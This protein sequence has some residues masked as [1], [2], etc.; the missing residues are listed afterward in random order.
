M[1]DVDR[2]A[3]TARGWATGA[4]RVY[5]PL[6][7]ELVA[8]APH[9]LAGRRVLDAGAGTGLASAA[10]RAV[11]ARP[12]AMDRSPAML[13]WDAAARP[14]AVAGALE[15]VPLRDGCVDDTVAAFVLNHVDDPTAALRELAR[16]TR[17]GG[18]VLASLPAASSDHRAVRDRIDAVVVEAGW[19]PPEW[20]AHLTT[21]QSPQLG[22]V[23]AAA[24]AAD[25]AGLAVVA[26]TEHVADVGVERAEDLVDYRLG[27]AH[28]AAW[29]AA[30]PDAERAALR[31]TAVDAVRPV[32]AP[33]R[34]PVITLVARVP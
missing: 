28:V 16:V 22:D 34:P 26:V 9:P 19:V 32:M 24:R 4:S 23:A 5:G 33:Y 29:L 25:E 18:A 6:A 7:A 10:L 2:Y 27:Q 31:A 8:A 13:G 11:G 15:A 3:A 30:M 1:H 12:V 17:R 21:V 20:H 14:P